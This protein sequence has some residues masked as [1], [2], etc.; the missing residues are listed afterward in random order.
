ML[1]SL[2]ASI[3]N[4]FLGNYVSNLNYDQ[5]NIGIW[6]GAVTTLLREWRNVC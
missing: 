4:R 2:I 6:N 1:E 3:L 5:L